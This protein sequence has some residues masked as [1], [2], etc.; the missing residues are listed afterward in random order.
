[1][2]LRDRA[3]RAVSSALYHSRLLGPVATAAGYARP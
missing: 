1:M 2:S 3:I